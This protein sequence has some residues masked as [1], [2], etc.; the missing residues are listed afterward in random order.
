[1]SYPDFLVEPSNSTVVRPASSL[2]P[3]TAV[4]TLTYNETYIE[5]SNGGNS[6]HTWAINLSQ[7]FTVQ[8]YYYMP[9]FSGLVHPSIPDITLSGP[10]MYL[11]INIYPAPWSPEP[12]SIRNNVASSA[13]VIGGKFQIFSATTNIG[14]LALSGTI[15]AG[16]VNDIRMS[17]TQVELDILQLNKVGLQLDANRITQHTCIRKNAILNERVRDGVTVLFPPCPP[18]FGTPTPLQGQTMPTHSISYVAPCGNPAPF[19][20]SSCYTADV[21]AYNVQ[22]PAILPNSRPAFSVNMSCPNDV[23]GG[24]LLVASVFAYTVIGTTTPGLYVVNQEFSIPDLTGSAQPTPMP[25]TQFVP[26]ASTDQ[27][28][29]GLLPLLHPIWVGTL[30][31]FTM[32]AGTHPTINFVEVIDPLANDPGANGPWA[33]IAVDNVSKGQ[34]IIVAGEQFLEYVPLGFIEPYISRSLAVIV[35]LEELCI[36]FNDEKSQMRN[37]WFTPDYNEFIGRA[38]R[39]GDVPKKM[40]RIE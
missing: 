10:A 9:A 20:V 34:E 18:T 15:S 3:Y 14:S 13:R 36:E 16:V 11:P 28:I 7:P 31:Q 22:C 8:H 12:L 23:V 33:L 6:R 32:T 4:K 25:L 26:P 19:W 27:V 38:Q 24:K 30:F 17:N 40:R 1:M 21:G 37:I 35:N 2:C 5:P 29:S 39:T